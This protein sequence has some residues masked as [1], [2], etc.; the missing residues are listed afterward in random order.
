VLP[1]RRFPDQPDFV[2]RLLRLAF[3]HMAEELYALISDRWPQVTPAQ[4]TVMILLDR[5]GLRVG[6]LA[7]RAQVNKQS[8]SEMVTALEKHG[9]V[10]RRPDPTDGR[11]RLVMPTVEGWEAMRAGLEAALAIHRRWQVIIGPEKMAALM[12]LLRELVDRLEAA[13]PG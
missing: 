6:D 11:A 8:M 1:A 3:S 9:L 12:E 7:V 4:A 13:P 2:G 10:E 5:E